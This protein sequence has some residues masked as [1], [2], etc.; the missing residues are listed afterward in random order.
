MIKCRTC[1]EWLAKEKYSQYELNKTHSNPDCK[2]CQYDK[3]KIYS[4]KKKIQK[5][6]DDQFFKVIG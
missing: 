3:N 2:E 1:K 4:M 6:Y 5:E